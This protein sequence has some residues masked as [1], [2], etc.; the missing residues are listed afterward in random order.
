LKASAKVSLSRRAVFY[1]TISGS[2][3]L[4]GHKQRNKGD[5][6]EKKNTDFV[7]CHCRIMHGVELFNGQTEP[8]AVESVHPLMGQAED[9][10]PA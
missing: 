3:N 2:Y 9:E 4:S 7:N 5:E 1:K 10:K 8:S 6:V